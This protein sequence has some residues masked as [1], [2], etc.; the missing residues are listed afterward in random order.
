[1]TTTTISP[2]GTVDTIESKKAYT[3]AIYIR[4]YNSTATDWHL[5]RYTT[6]EELAIKQAETYRNKI[7]HANVAIV[8]AV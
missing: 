3:H 8:P 7:G 6:R 1:M 2:S 4:N 5:I